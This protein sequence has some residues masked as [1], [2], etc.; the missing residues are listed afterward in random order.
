M[1]KFNQNNEK[2]FENKKRVKQYIKNLEIN[3][4]IIEYYTY[5]D[6]DM[7]LL[8]IEKEHNDRI[9]V[10]EISRNEYIDTK[11][12]ENKINKLVNNPFII[13][14]CEHP[15]TN[16]SDTNKCDNVRNI[17][18]DSEY[19]NKKINL[20]VVRDILYDI[21]FY[22]KYD[23]EIY[24]DRQKQD[25]KLYDITKRYNMIKNKEELYLYSIY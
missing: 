20:C 9:F 17:I 19:R 21:I 24:I 18:I 14:L 1:N 12:I 13:E 16:Y 4:V 8:E 15:L 10:L 23:K 11:Y 5:L 3:D 2:I 7:K 25:Q 22:E 6:N